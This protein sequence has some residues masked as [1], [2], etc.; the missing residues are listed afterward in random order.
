MR[1]QREEERGVVP[2]GWATGFLFLLSP[3][4]AIILV[5]PCPSWV[6]WRLWE[7]RGTGRCLGSEL[8]DHKWGEY[9]NTKFPTDPMRQGES[10]PT[11][12]APNPPT[13]LISHWRREEEKGRGSSSLTAYFKKTELPKVIAKLNQMRF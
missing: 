5:P 9:R 12:P 4:R 2:G 6:I 13:M 3:A 7:S 10:L 8:R 11:S 1:R